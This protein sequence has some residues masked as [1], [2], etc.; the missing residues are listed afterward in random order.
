M[1]PRYRIFELQDRFPSTLVPIIMFGIGIFALAP[2]YAFRWRSPA[3]LFFTWVIPIIPFVLVFDGIISALRTR[4]REEVEALLRS[5]GADSDG[6][7]IHNGVETIARPVGRMNWIVA[8][9]RGSGFEDGGT[10]RATTR[11]R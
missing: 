5:C 8:V 2:F 10:V 7:E 4:T 1:S 6:W 11:R 3:T 9:K